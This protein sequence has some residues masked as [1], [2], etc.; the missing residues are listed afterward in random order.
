MARFEV[1]ILGNGSALSAYGRHPSSQIINIHEQYLLLDCGEGTQDRLSQFH[2]KAHR[3]DHIFI[4]H[5]H[6]DHYFGLP[7]LINSLN[8]T[9]RKKILHIYS[10][11]GLKALINMMFDLAHSILNF[12]IVWVEMEESK[13]CILVD[14]PIKQIQAFH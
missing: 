4:S 2:I 12:E 9:G 13:S 3:I 7:G 10:P 6:G 11:K 14:D 5:L 1:L 8:L